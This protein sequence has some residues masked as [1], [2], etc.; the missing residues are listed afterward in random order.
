MDETQG[1]EDGINLRR[2]E[3]HILSRESGGS[4]WEHDTNISKNCTTKKTIP[5]SRE[6][7]V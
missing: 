4:G 5:S 1:Q 7:V 3:E 6:R 2:Q